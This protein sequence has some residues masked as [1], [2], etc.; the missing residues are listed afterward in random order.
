MD[1]RQFLATAGVAIGSLGVVLPER[2]LAQPT[3]QSSSTNWHVHSSEALDAVAF[4]GA[5]SGGELYLKRYDKEAAEFGALL[6]Q[7]VRADLVALRDEADHGGFGLLWPGLATILS[8]TRASAL[9]DLIVAL[10]Q[11]E[12]N[13]RKSYE[14]SA[15]WDEKDWRWFAAAAPRLHT[16]F[17]AMQDAGFPAYR[18]RLVGDTL[19]AKAAELQRALSEFDVSQWQR[20][21]T[22]RDFDP[23]IEIILLYFSEPH[24]VRVQGQCF[25]QSTAY[26]LTTTLRIAAHEMLHPPI[27]MK[28]PVAQAALSA[29]GKDQLLTRIVR[30]HDPRWGYTTLDGYLNEDVCQAL[31][32]LISEALGFARN[33]ADRWRKS[34]DGMHVLAAGLYGLLR[35]DKWVEKGG[36]IEGW[37]DQANSTGRLAPANLHPVAAQVLERP[38]DALWPLPDAKP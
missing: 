11:P 18:R 33:P 9:G 17:A 24:G 22:G 20:K 32:Q 2:L 8:G 34:D 10:G 3:S 29:L 19:D 1:R 5:L 35:Q 31:D 7:Q 30:D 14:A 37:L 21:L 28:G 26:G 27:D 23:N 6:P 16:V 36:S 25:L 12:L 13:V 15:Y 38:V 4:L